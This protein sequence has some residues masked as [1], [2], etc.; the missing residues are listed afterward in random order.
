MLRGGTRSALAARG[1]CRALSILGKYYRRRD[2]QCSEAYEQTK[3][4]LTARA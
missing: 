3:A 2:A 4:R 1:A